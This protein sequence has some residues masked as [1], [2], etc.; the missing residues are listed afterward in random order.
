[1]PFLV[2]IVHALVYILCFNETAAEEWL[3]AAS[4][5]NRRD[6]LALPE[7]IVGVV[8]NNGI[9]LRARQRERVW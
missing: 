5:K 9:G 7:G 3:E 8:K 4:H 1:M 2:K 6:N